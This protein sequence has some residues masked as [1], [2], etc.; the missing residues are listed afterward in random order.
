[1][2]A[3][4]DWTDAMIV[5]L[6]DLHAEEET[7]S[8]IARILSREFGVKLS[9][10]ACIG[11]GRRLG[12]TA[13]AHV[14]PPKPRKGQNRSGPRLKPAVLPGWQVEP[15][16]LPPT[17]GRITIYQLQRGVCHFPYGDAPP[18][19]YC[20]NTAFRASSWCPHHERVVYPQGRIR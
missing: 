5:R 15:P 18:Y 20:G 13:R 3:G 10:N 2:P 14:P 12:L 4:T 9:K 17:T 8:V 7:F 1:M 11:K 16:R 6:R 19:V